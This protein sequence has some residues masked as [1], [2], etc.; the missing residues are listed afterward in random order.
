MNHDQQDQQKK[1]AGR[2]PLLDRLRAEESPA[3]TIAAALQGYFTAK[4]DGNVRI[5]HIGC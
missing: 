3:K 1:G 2:P 5:V 4:E